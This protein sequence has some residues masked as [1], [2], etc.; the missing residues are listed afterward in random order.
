MVKAKKTQLAATEQAPAVVTEQA[1]PPVDLSAYPPLLKVSEVVEVTRLS[2]STV[3]ALIDGG[4]IVSLK[5]GES[6]RV[7]RA[8]VEAY[9]RKCLRGAQ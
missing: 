8:S 7:S 5:M 3:Y 4:Q 9:M 1:P 2:K 6:L